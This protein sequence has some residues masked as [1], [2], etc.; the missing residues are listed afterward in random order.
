M[1]RVKEITY[2]KKAA[3]LDRDAA[4]RVVKNGLWEP[5]PKK[6]SKVAKKRKK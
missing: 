6:A 5:K 2:K 3:K 1:N 4:S